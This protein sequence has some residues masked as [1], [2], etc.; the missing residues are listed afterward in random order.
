MIFQRSVVEDVKS[1]APQI[2]LV[3]SLNL[4]FPKYQN[5]E[6]A[7]DIKKLCNS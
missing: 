2:F 6:K 3:F 7:K 5:P 4:V 1:W